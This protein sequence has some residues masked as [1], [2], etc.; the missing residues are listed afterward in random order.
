MKIFTSCFNLSRVVKL[1]SEIGAACFLGG[2]EVIFKYAAI[3]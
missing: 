2:V 3:F 1:E